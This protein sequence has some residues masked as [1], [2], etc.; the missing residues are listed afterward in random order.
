MPL[1]VIIVD[2][3]YVDRVGIEED[4]E[5]LAVDVDTVLE[6]VEVIID[7]EL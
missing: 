1:E 6:D 2:E 3:E 7:E 5:L 4:M